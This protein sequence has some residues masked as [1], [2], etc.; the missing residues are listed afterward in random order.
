MKQKKGRLQAPLF[1]TRENYRV[2]NVSVVS[3]GTTACSL[4]VAYATPVPAAA[5]A[6]APIKAPLPPPANPP[7]SAPAPVPTPI[8][9]TLP[10]V[11][12]LP[13]KL[14]ELVETGMP[15]TDTSA[16][17]RM[18]G[19]C[20]RPL[21]LALTTLPCTESPRF[22]TTVLP[23]FTSLTSVPSNVAPLETLPES[24]VEPVRMVMVVPAGIVLAA[25][26]V[27][28]A[29]KITARTIE[30]FFI[31]IESLL[32][33]SELEITIPRRLNDA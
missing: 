17:R 10:L 23:F 29:S 26:A 22:A 28:V 16:R 32:N 13:W 9:V 1:S 7:I 31:V 14:R 20:R 27:N 25:A 6:P 5:P 4:P 2:V 33:P 18:P 11:W 24:R 19:L 8:L 30:S 12:L 3:A 21:S 15:F